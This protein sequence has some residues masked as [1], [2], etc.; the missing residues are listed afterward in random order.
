MNR[1]V[2][3]RAE[4]KTQETTGGRGASVRKNEKLNYQLLISAV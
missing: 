4:E 3:N 1:R 2:E